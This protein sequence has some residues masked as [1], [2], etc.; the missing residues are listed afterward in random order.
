MYFVDL[1][2]R[3]RDVSQGILCGSLNVFRYPQ[4]DVVALCILAKLKASRS[5]NVSLYHI[6]Q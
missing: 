1:Q 6:V 5:S 4:V 2:P 3:A